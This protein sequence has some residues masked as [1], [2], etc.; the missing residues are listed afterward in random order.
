MTEAIELR[1]T[2]QLGHK[3]D[4][5]LKSLRRELTRLAKV[6]P[7]Y[8]RIELESVSPNANSGPYHRQ[9]VATWTEY[10]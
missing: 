5:R 7:D 2:R 1:A 3:S 4:V 6:V 10:R 8:A 9:L